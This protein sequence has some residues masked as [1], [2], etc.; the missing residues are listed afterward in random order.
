MKI[1]LSYGSEDR[2]AAERIYLALAGHHHT[3]F[4]DRA[5]LPPGGEYNA[6][7]RQAILDS[8]LLVFLVSDDSVAPSSYALTE[9]ALA[10]KKWPHPGQAVLPVM[11]RVSDYDRIPNYLKAVSILQ[12]RG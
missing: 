4:F 3:V 12:P 1:F 2:N 8:D 6:R 10:E 5:S 7:I 9:L 11:V